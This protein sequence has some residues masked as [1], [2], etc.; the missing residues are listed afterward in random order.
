MP[1]L[2]LLNKPAFSLYH[3]KAIG[4]NFKPADRSVIEQ[5]AL[6]SAILS[7]SDKLGGIVD[8]GSMGADRWLVTQ[9]LIWSLM[10][11]K[12]GVFFCSKWP[13]LCF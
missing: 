13:H 3:E 6:L 9:V 7:V 1:Q 11:D 2:S 4:N 10:A 8:N 5:K 12:D